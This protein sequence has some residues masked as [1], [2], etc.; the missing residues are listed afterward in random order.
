MPDAKGA[1]GASGAGAYPSLAA[2][3]RLVSSAY[4]AI[5]VLRGHK[6]M[7][8]FGPNLSD[9]QIA[10]VI[11]YLRTHFGNAYTDSITPRTVKAL[12]EAGPKPSGQTI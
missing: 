4:P 12:S 3:T 1:S 11:N 2:N 6:A 8:P 5:I 9:G 10:D 7:P